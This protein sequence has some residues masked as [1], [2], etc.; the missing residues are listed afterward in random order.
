[1]NQRRDNLE[2]SDLDVYHIP[3]NPE[4]A[5]LCTRGLK[6]LQVEQFGPRFRRYMV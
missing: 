3:K 2:D 1:M 5:R 4:I 6:Y